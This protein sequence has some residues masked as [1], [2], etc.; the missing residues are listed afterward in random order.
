MVE[1]VTVTLTL[2]NTFPATNY[3]TNFTFAFNWS[4]TET[5]EITSVWPYMCCQTS[6]TIAW[7]YVLKNYKDWNQCL[8]GVQDYHSHRGGKGQRKNLWQKL[9]QYS[10]FMKGKYVLC[11]EAWWN[12]TWWWGSRQASLLCVQ[13][14][15]SRKD[16]SS[17]RSCSSNFS[18]KTVQSTIIQNSNIKPYLLSTV[19]N[20]V[21]LQN[22]S[23]QEKHSDHGSTFWNEANK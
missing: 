18:Q 2:G 4:D 8:T 14:Q 9:Q 6:R 5:G 13:R 23:A 20:R 1:R 15:N 3:L 16:F 10:C 22:S 7:R 21:L 11:H 17:H 19:P 12:G